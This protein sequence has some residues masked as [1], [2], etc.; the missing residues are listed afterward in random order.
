[1]SGGCNADGISGSAGIGRLVYESIFERK[2]SEHVKSLS[3]DRFTEHSWNWKDAWRQA[4]HI[5]ETYYGV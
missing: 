1:M 4:A 2:P 3:Q 5:Y